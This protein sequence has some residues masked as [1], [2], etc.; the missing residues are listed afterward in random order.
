[1]FTYTGFRSII[2]ATEKFP[3]G[4]GIWSPGMELWWAFEQLFSLRSGE[5]SKN[6]PKIQIPGEL[7][8]GDV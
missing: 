1:M 3:G 5:F 2:E 7:P 6:V 8:G 4:G